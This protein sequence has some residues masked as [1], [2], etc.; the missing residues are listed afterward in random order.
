MLSPL[1]QPC[2]H[3]QWASNTLV[4]GNTHAQQNEKLKS[5]ISSYKEDLNLLDTKVKIKN[6]KAILN[7]LINRHVEM[8]VTKGNK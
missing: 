8:I 4:Y 7:S 3:E 2:H 6:L 1:R 5:I